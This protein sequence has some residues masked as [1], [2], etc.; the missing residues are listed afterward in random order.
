[1]LLKITLAAALILFFGYQAFAYMQR[2][3]TPTQPYRLVRRIGEL[4]LRFYP[5]A[6][7]ATVHKN[8]EYRTLMNDG[9]RD[10]ASYIF[11]GND[12]Q[13]KIAMTAPVITVPDEKGADVS[14]V[15]PEGFNLEQ[16]PQPTRV[17]NIQ[18]RETEAVYTASLTFGGFANKEKME[19][20]S[21]RLLTE[22]G[23]AGLAAGGPVQHLYYNAPFDL[24]GR[25]N[26]VLVALKDFT[27]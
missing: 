15:M 10:L 3:T 25:R 8:G 18:F 16:R 23:T 11:G 22:L 5:P 17:R 14:F 12:R 7:T 2:D 20:M 1:M 27:E 6:V 24:F 13:E 21:E 4:E 9:F 26:E 19:D